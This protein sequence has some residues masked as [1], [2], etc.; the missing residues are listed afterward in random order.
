MIVQEILRIF[1]WFAFKFYSHRDLKLVILWS[2]HFLYNWKDQLSWEERITA[3]IVHVDLFQYVGTIVKAISGSHWLHCNLL[4]MFQRP[5]LKTIPVSTAG[6]LINEKRWR[7]DKRSQES[8]I[9]YLLTIKLYLIKFL[10][11]ISNH[12]KF[13]VFPT[14]VRHILEI[15]RKTAYWWIYPDIFCTN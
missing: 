13:D 14:K 11:H 12:I 5:T 2:N 7:D 4:A 9:Y 6:L 1:Y 10:F 15:L 8:H 3:V